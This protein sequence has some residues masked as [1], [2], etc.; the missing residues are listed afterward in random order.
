M[1]RSALPPVG[2]N[3][4]NAEALNPNWL[5]AVTHRTKIEERK[6]PRKAWVL[7]A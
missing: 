4:D 3:L 2:F 1:S 6:C 5:Q 7:S